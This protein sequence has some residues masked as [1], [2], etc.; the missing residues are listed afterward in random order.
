[1]STPSLTQVKI[2]IIKYKKLKE[3]NK[4]KNELIYNY[5]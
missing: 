3:K 5:L 4:K 2:E 1:M